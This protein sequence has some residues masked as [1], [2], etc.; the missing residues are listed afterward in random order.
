MC[1]LP[2]SFTL[3]ANPVSMVTLLMRFW[4]NFPNSTYAIPIRDCN[5]TSVRYGTRLFK[6]QKSMD[7]PPLLSLFSQRSATF[8]SPYIKA[9]MLHRLHSLLTP[10]SSTKSCSS[11]RHIH[12]ATS[13][14]IAQTQPL[15]FLFL[16]PSN[17]GILP[18]PRLTHPLMSPTP[19]RDNP[20]K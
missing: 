12:S 20:S 3:L 8:T 9:P 18:M 17:L 1:Y 10:T 11:R 19:L 2:S 4:K 16:F 5:M 7:I 14:A 15:T 6:K 13:L